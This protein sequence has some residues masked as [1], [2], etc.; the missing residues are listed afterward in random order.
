MNDQIKGFCEPT[1]KYFLQPRLGTIWKG[2]TGFL[3]FVTCQRILLFLSNSLDLLFIFV[4]SE[5]GVAG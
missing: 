1:F 5:G 4:D 2:G 3:E